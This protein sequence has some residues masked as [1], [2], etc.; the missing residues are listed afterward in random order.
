MFAMIGCISQIRDLSC[1][2]LLCIFVLVEIPQFIQ[3]QISHATVIRGC[4]FIHEFFPCSLLLLYQTHGHGV[5][6]IDMTS[7]SAIVT[8]QVMFDFVFELLDIA[9]WIVIVH[10]IDLQGYILV[11]CHV[12]HHCVT[13]CLIQW[14][15]M[16]LHIV[17]SNKEQTVYIKHVSEFNCDHSGVPLTQQVCFAMKLFPLVVSILV[18][19]YLYGLSYILLL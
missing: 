18:L 10:F 3:E 2:K 7:S 16:F 11:P 14:K 6:D 1:S 13:E 12:V 4:I 9:L 5:T 17:T 8:E 15:P 19:A